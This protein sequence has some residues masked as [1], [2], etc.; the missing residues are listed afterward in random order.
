[1][2]GTVMKIT[3]R[4]IVVL[5]EDGT[6]CNLPQPPSL[7]ALGDTITL[8]MERS[9]G[10]GR[11][12]MRSFSRI[13][14]AAAALLLFVGAFISV[15]LKHASVE[16]LTLVAIDINPS[17]EMTVDP[18]GEI[19]S[20][21][22]NNEE[23]SGLAA[24]ID[25]E[26]EPFDRS[27][28]LLVD[29]AKAQGYLN[30]DDPEKRW[31]FVSI[32]GP[33]DAMWRE[34]IS[35]VLPEDGPLRLHMYTAS[36]EQ[37]EQAKQAELPLN[38][39][40]VYEEARQRGI[41]LDAE[42]LRHASIASTFVKAGVELE[43]F[44][45]EPKAVGGHSP[46][47]PLSSPTPVP[48]SGKKIGLPVASVPAAQAQ[49]SIAGSAL[50]KSKQEFPAASPDNKD[51]PPEQ[52]KP[53]ADTPA[54]ALTSTPAASPTESPAA[55]P[56]ASPAPTPTVRSNSVQL[57]E[58]YVR[59]T[60]NRMLKANF[61]LSD[62][63]KETYVERLSKDASEKLLGQAAIAEIGKLIDDLGLSSGGIDAAKLTNE[64]ILSVAGISSTEWLEIQL[65]VE[66]TDG[67]QL[68]IRRLPE[69]RSQ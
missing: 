40:I 46:Q 53:S 4:Y 18:K 12:R 43:Q 10:G 5:C 27:F 64:R 32:V 39:Y 31:V 16:P 33:M 65:K 67:Q 68:Q 56:V 36:M 9:R 29:R 19:R 49:T 58:L 69:N 2:R 66:W 54:P 3:D 47:L 59:G 6:F 42:M 35:R 17:M 55:S 48:D 22:W 1:M 61:R 26:G 52:K 60:N 14:V 7:S 62:S 28:Q 20:V 15:Y 57:L 37:A 44:L 8:P 63:Q 41:E 45:E 38:K 51:A 30:A 50:P 21:V 11:R 34:G 24:A 25:F 23:A 13:W